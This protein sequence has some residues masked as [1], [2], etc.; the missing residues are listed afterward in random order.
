MLEQRGIGRPSTFSALIDKIQE[1][2][3]VKKENITGKTIK[4]IDMEL[5][6]DKISKIMIEKEFGNEKNKLVIQPMGIFV[7]EF[8]LKYFDSLFAYD[9]TKKME[10]NLDLI[11]KGES[12]WY[13]LCE[14]CNK[15]LILLMGPVS[16]KSSKEIIQID[17]KHAYMIGKYG[18]VIKYEDEGKTSFLV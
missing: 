2:N 3:Y 16:K 18:P 9:Y 10:D 1:R 12:I 15:E 6:K 7:L 8:L 17:K 5:E 14:E 13:E 11:A 4:C